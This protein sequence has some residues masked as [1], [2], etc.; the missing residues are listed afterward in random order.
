MRKIVV[1]ENIKA[2]REG[3]KI[4]IDRFSDFQCTHSF[5]DFE[6]L[7]KNLYKLNPDILLI[8]QNLKGISVLEEIKG[9][10]KGNPEIIIIILTMN[11][12]DDNLFYAM[13][14]G[15]SA[16]INKN[17]PSL[18]LIKSLQDISN[19]KIIII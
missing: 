19:G 6:S 3:I 8:D 11:E 12:E 9:I 2:I 16:Y 4:F 13:V 15:A 17:S 18:K 1:V 5:S 14:N 10:K 7:N